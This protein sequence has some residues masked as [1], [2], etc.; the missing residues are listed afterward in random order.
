MKILNVHFID[1]I[2]EYII[3]KVSLKLIGEKV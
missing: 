1:L 2:R 3:D